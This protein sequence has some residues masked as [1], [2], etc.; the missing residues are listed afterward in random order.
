MDHDAEEGACDPE[1]RGAARARRAGIIARLYRALDRKMRE[2]EARMASGE[3]LSPA[4]GERDARMMHALARLYEKLGEL[5][6]A[7]RADK[8]GGAIESAAGDKD[9][10]QF[11]HEIAAR[12]ERMLSREPD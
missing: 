8:E 5:E 2:I 9:A 4:D 3:S 11:R 12:L 10:E 6:A 1:M 7:E